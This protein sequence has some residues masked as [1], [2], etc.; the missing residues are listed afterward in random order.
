MV[1]EI[2]HK[3][4]KQRGKHGLTMLKLD[5]QKA[6][7]SLEW[8]FVMRALKLWGFSD[9]VR[10]M[11]FSCISSVT[12]SFSMETKQVLLLKLEV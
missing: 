11:L 8:S 10:S 6:Y 12:Y 4:Q 3:I 7:D 5:L 9:K 2:V 1:Q